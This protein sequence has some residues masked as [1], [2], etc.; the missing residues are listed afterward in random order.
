MIHDH[1]WSNS[2]LIQSSWRQS[3][4]A[5]GGHPD[6]SVNPRTGRQVPS[7]VSLPAID[8]IIIYQTSSKHLQTNVRAARNHLINYIIYELAQRL[9][10]FGAYW[11]VM[12]SRGIQIHFCLHGPRES[13]G[14]VLVQ[15]GGTRTRTFTVGASVSLAAESESFRAK[16]HASSQVVASMKLELNTLRITQDLSGSLV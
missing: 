15:G 12:Y 2:G 4:L 9:L 14:P 16:G 11:G 10:Y 3:T 6:S 13:T 8:I 7:R 1:W 5:C